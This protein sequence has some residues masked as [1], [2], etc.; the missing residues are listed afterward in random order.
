MTTKCFSGLL[1]GWSLSQGAV[2]D[3]KVENVSVGCCP[4]GHFHLFI[5]MIED[6]YKSFSGLLP[7]W[8][9]SLDILEYEDD[10]ILFQWAVAR[11]V[12]FT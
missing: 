9:L 1:P 12:T 7:G 11:M 6:F 8:S 5:K 3:G 2:T 10:S 4:D